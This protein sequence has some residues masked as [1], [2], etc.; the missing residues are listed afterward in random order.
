[1]IVFPVLFGL[2]T[3]AALGSIAAMVA[4]ERYSGNRLGAVAALWPLFLAAW[5]IRVVPLGW[6]MWLDLINDEPEDEDE[7]E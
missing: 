6:Q 5:L 1:V 2:I 7:T 3:Y 4:A